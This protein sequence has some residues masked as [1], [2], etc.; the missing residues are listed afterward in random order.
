MVDKVEDE[1]E[2]EE[3][4][5][6]PPPATSQ[7]S[8]L[9][10]EDEEEAFPPKST[11][12]PSDQPVATTITQTH[13]PVTPPPSRPTP[14]MTMTTL[15]TGGPDKNTEEEEGMKERGKKRDATEETVKTFQKE[16]RVDI[17]QRTT[18]SSGCVWLSP[19]PLVCVTAFFILNV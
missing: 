5:V 19:L 13:A 9:P 17:Y 3:E 1:V 4:M 12:S 16:I 7:P 15:D 6:F 14:E 10:A 11:A 2:P 8:L 18:S